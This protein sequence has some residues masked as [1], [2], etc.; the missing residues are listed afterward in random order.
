MSLSELLGDAQMEV[1]YRGKTI[2]V[3]P[4][5][6]TGISLLIKESSKSFD[7]LLAGEIK[8]NELLSDAPELAGRIMKLGTRDESP[9]EDVLNLPIGLQISIMKAI[10]ELSELDPVNLGKSIRRFTEVT[11]EMAKD[12]Q[13]LISKTESVKS[14]KS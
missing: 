4:L 1:K 6:L 7:S 13:P 11:G 10:W 14:S 5:S 8:M 9:L 12:L 3:Y 2:T